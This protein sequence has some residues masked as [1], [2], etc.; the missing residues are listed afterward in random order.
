MCLHHCPEHPVTMF[1]KPFTEEIV[2]NIQCKP[3]LQQPDTISLLTAA[4]FQAA[5]E[6]DKVF[7][8]LEQPQGPG[9]RFVMFFVVMDQKIAIKS[10]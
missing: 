6:S 7:S 2:P 3:T 10:L 5:V 4:S 1:D 9:T 8:L